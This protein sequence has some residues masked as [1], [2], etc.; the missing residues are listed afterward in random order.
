MRTPGASVMPYR[1]EWDSNKAEANASK[2]GVSFHDAVTV[3]G[4][5]LA[6]CMEDPDHGN[7]EQRFVLLGQTQSGRLL[8]VAYC[9]RTPLTRL[10]SA[11][12]ATARE[13][14]DYEQGEG[15]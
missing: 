13:R 6:R 10:I 15:A 9:E 8:V 2:H 5:Q 14:R 1:F 3:F 7:G 11:R 4:D 12:P